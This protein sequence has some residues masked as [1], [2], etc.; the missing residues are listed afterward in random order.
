MLA[1]AN[2]SSGAAVW[3]I[4][5]VVVYDVTIE[6]QQH[7]VLA[8]SARGSSKS[9][10]LPETTIESAS[11]GSMTLEIGSTDGRG[12]ARAAA[13]LEF[14]GHSG[15]RLTSMVRSVPASI[16]AN[17]RISLPGF[18]D[19]IARA[20]DLAGDAI[21]DAVAH[22]AKP[23]SAWRTT[24][25]LSGMPGSLTFARVIQTARPYQGYPTVGVLSSGSTSFQ[26]A[27]QTGK[28]SIASSAYYDPRDRMLVGAAVRSFALVVNDKGGHV[29]S[30]AT[31]N[32]ALREVDRSPAGATPEPSPR[33]SPPPAPSAARLPPPAVTP[34]PGA[35]GAPTS[36]PM[37]PVVLPSMG[38][39][40]V[41]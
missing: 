2:P 10:P 25:R 24:E 19:A 21:S 27:L 11:S 15:G 16:D 1:A 30:T 5:D 13:D 41:F 37:T 35:T 34:I 18:D 7:Q 3:H 23:A 14:T 8:R 36:T 20:L 4:G 38:P 26:N 31:V 17:G 6:L 29:E 32:I 28:L 33:S 40:S 39:Q 22:G 12:D 9:S